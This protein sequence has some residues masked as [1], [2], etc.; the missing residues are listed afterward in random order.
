[1]NRGTNRATAP[2]SA[3]CRR[4]RTGAEPSSRE[5]LVGGNFTT[6]GG[7]A[8]SRIAR[9]NGAWWAFGSR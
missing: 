3:P 5:T 2:S 1:M 8:A 6:I 7:V 9:W 4:R